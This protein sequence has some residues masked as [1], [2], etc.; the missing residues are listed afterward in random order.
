MCV[1]YIY[2]PAYKYH[3]ALQ[4]CQ[5]I[6]QLSCPHYLSSA[7]HHLFLHCWDCVMCVNIMQCVEFLAISVCFVCSVTSIAPILLGSEHPESIHVR[8]SPSSD[9]DIAARLLEDIA[10][11]R[12]V[13]PTYKHTSGEPEVK[14][15]THSV[16]RQHVNPRNEEDEEGMGDK[17]TG[18]YGFVVAPAHT[19]L[20]SNM[21][22]DEGNNR[23]SN[24][25]INRTDQNGPEQSL[26]ISRDKNSS[27]VF[28]MSNDTEL[29][30]I[31]T[32]SG[33]DTG[34]NMSTWKNTGSEN[35]SNIFDF[36]HI[37][38]T[39]QFTWI[40]IVLTILCTAAFVLLC[41]NV[42]LLA[43]YCRKHQRFSPALT[44][45]SSGGTF[46][47]SLR[48]RNEKF[49]VRRACL[50]WGN[51]RKF[52]TNVAFPESS[53]IGTSS[54]DHM[55]AN[56]VSDELIGELNDRDST[57]TSVS[58]GFVFSRS[59]DTGPLCTTVATIF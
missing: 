41:V 54:V 30:E 11:L 39:V 6:W 55:I 47:D 31:D 20:H 2:T 5:A 24:D 33:N 23:Q 38:S 14:P 40:D 22:V 3:I 12:S 9:D 13:T 10:R 25:T 7:N 8:L 49:L 27:Y 48:I 21:S 53:P 52:T 46:N 32:G 19:E 45:R 1:Y 57:C 16:I 37:I 44:T 35:I 17:S 58:D 34:R 36:L 15:T 50:G 18:V 29:V 56:F 43:H 28:R 59:Y 51:C 26:V 4:Q 42:A